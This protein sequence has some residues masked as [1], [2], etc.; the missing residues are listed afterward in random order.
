MLVAKL[1]GSTYAP[2][3]T[4][5]GPRKGTSAR[6]PRVWPLSAFSAARRTRSSP[7]SATATASGASLPGS[8]ATSTGVG[9]SGGVLTATW[10]GSLDEHAAGQPEGDADTPALDPDSD[11]TLVLA[12]G[13]DFDPR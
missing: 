11:R 5:A 6:R 1:P 7:G 3:A 13:Q 2:A 10:T 9:D 12:N 8:L 4:K